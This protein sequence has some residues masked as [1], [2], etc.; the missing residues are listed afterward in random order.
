[1]KRLFFLVPVVIFAGLAALFYAGLYGGPP[2]ILPSPL[3]GK[4]AP[5]M[6][7]PA[8]DAQSEGF[9]REELAKGKPTIVNFWASW[10]APCRVEHP[11]L[12]AL[13]QTGQ[14]A[15]YGVDYKDDP[16][17]ARGFLTEL[18][19]PFGDKINMD[20]EGRVSIDW[21]VTGVPETFVIDGNGVIR[22]HYAGPLSDDVLQRVIMPAV[23]AA[24]GNAKD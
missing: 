23:A 22:A 1:V 12:E 24:S 3:V 6:T 14:V 13:A 9:S 4:L 8:L 21:G 11:T 2:N 5:E 18:G 19:N 10:C 20:R 15:L 16:A 7:L 17:A